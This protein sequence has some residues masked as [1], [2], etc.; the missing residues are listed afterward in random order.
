M[1]LC[2]STSVKEKEVLEQFNKADVKHEGV[3]DH[4]SVES[5][6]SSHAELWAMLGVNLGLEDDVCK[7]IATDVAFSMVEGVGSNQNRGTMTAEQFSA[8]YQAVKTPKG[9]LEFFHRT[10][11]QAFDKDNN[12]AID[13]A[14]LDKFLDTFYDS[15]SIFKG[16][17]RLP[18]KEELKKL[19]N[20]KLDSDHNGE[21]SFDEI[22]LLISG[23]LE[24][25][26]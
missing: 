1:G 20:E 24:F 4:S 18:E 9:Q 12:G 2:A 7:S 6:V 25:S 8:F 17:A 14:E 16:D 26:N 15:H 5:Y 13:Q 11:F 21:L 22:H 23:N 3:L 19:V 10:I